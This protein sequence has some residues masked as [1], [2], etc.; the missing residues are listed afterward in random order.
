[1]QYK[2]QRHTLVGTLKPLA[3]TPLR[4]LARSEIGW[5]E[6][7]NVR[8]QPPRSEIGWDEPGNVRGQPPAQVVQFE[9][10]EGNPT[11]SAPDKA[12]TEEL[13]FAG[14]IMHVKVLNHV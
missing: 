6:P 5:D 8:G 1:M 12:I 14:K 10:A 4:P 11:P 3:N 13:A 2:C 7:G 9:E